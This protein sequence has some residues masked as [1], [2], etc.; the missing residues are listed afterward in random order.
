V[1]KIEELFTH[2]DAGV[3]ALKRVK[4]QLKRYRQ[5]VLKHAF[6]GKLTETWP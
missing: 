1:A 2:L 3:E 4:A 6:E 5:A